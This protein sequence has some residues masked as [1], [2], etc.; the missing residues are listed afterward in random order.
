[1]KP[2]V[3]VS[4]NVESRAHPPIDEQVDEHDPEFIFVQQAG[5][6]HAMLERL[7]GYRSKGFRFSAEARGIRILAKRD[8]KILQKKALVMAL[9][10]RGPKAGKWHLPRVYLALQVEY[11]G[12]VFWIL[13]VHLPTANSP[14]AQAESLWRIARFLKNHGECVAAG[15]YNLDAGRMRAWAKKHSF[16]VSVLG[17]VDY[18]VTDAFRPEVLARREAPRGFHGWGAVEYK[19]KRTA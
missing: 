14:K 5:R 10:W 15:D 9:P 12:E 13:C 2:F 3:I 19:E 18:S 7:E 4:L 1:M 11:D 17:A 8:I 16:K 6:A